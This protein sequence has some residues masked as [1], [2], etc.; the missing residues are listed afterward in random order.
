MGKDSPHRKDL[1]GTGSL[2]AEMG[3]KERWNNCYTIHSEN[4]FKLSIKQNRKMFSSMEKLKTH[5]FHTHIL[6]K[7]PEDTLQHNKE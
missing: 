2:N 7:L 1:H 5:D 3:S 4:Y 6:R